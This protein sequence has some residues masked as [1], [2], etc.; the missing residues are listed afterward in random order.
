MDWGIAVGAMAVLAVAVLV[1]DPKD[2]G[3][4]GAGRDGEPS[5]ACEPHSA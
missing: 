3:L 2:L 4:A 1:V 5:R